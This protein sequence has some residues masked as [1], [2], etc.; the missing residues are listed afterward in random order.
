MRVEQPNVE[1]LMADSQESSLPAPR[2]GARLLLPAGGTAIRRL[3][4]PRNSAAER[5]QS[6]R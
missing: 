2:P 1:G 6:P 4:S 3:S 5:R